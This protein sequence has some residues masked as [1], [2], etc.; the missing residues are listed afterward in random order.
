VQTIRADFNGN[1]RVQGLTPGRYEITFAVKPFKQQVHAITLR[2]GE[3][4]DASTQMLSGRDARKKLL[5][6]LGALLDLW[7]VWSL[8]T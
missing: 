3:T 4:V 1:F 5:R 8:L 2:R 6:F 7:L